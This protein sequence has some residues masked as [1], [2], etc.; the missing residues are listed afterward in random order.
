MDRADVL[1]TQLDAEH[2]LH[3]STDEECTKRPARQIRGSGDGNGVVW[4]L[5]W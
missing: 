5:F 2:E 4:R 1:G 3:K